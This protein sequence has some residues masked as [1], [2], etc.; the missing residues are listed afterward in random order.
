MIYFIVII[1]TLPLMA[2]IGTYRQKRAERL[3]GLNW[4]A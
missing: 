4:N 1:F 2:L 3:R